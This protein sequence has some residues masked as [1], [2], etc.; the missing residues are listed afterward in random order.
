M[1]NHNDGLGCFRGLKIGLPLGLLCW[2]L[3]ILVVEWGL[4]HPTIAFCD[5]GYLL[6]FA[7][8][9]YCAAWGRKRWGMK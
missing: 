1:T 3:I 9:W 7:G 5:L 2:A 6:S 8:G 4:R